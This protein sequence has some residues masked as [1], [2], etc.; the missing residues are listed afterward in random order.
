MYIFASDLFEK[1][2]EYL[3]KARIRLCEGLE[4]YAFKYVFCLFQNISKDY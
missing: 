4:G 1:G 2:D 3:F